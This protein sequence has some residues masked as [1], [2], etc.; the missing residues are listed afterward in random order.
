MYSRVV[1][2][3]TLVILCTGLAWVGLVLFYVGCLALR[4][5]AGTTPTCRIPCLDRR[6]ANLRTRV[7]RLESCTGVIGPVEITPYDGSPPRVVFLRTDE[8]QTSG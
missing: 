8:C 1:A 5:D 3:A 2:R 4:T 7:R 6:V